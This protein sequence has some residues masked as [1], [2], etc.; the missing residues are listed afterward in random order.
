MAYGKKIIEAVVR[1][2]FH[3]LKIEN[4]FTKAY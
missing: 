3:G 2:K 4:N 1:I